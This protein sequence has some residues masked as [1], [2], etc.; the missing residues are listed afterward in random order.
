M[1]NEVTTYGTNASGNLKESIDDAIYTISPTDTVFMNLIN[2]GT[3]TSTKE[4]W[5]EDAD[6]E[7]GVNAKPEEWR[8]QASAIT[9]PVR[10]F[11]FVQ[12]FGEYIEIT[13]TMEMVA[14]YGRKS[15]IKM[16]IKKGIREL[17]KDIEFALLNNTAAPSASVAGTGAKMIGAKGFI[18]TNVNSFS[19]TTS[20]SNDLT[21]TSFN[22]GVQAAWNSGG[23]P[24]IVIGPPSVVRTISSFTGNGKMSYNSDATKHMIGMSVK[25]YETQFAGVLAIYTSRHIAPKSVSS[26]DY[27]TMFVM[28]PDKWEI[29]WLEKVSAKT[30]SET[31]FI[32]PVLISGK[33][34]LKCYNE[35]ANFKMENISRV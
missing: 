7:P 12:N 31:G 32:K 8:G 30:Q 34:T 6:R 20:A 5:L 33:A 28:Q 3:A 18:T 2:K 16:R 29:A 4:E 35:A 14:K 10:K 26:V 27:D 22:D 17:A 23:S 19:G 9:Q 21:E 24:S 11:N 25:Y 13:D 1:G 15:E